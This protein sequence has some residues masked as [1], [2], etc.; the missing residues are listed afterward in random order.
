MKFATFFMFA[1][2]RRW[3]ECVYTRILYSTRNNT[4]MFARIR[5]TRQLYVSH[6]KQDALHVGTERSFSGT[7]CCV[8]DHSCSDNRTTRD[9]LNQIRRNRTLG[10]RQSESGNERTVIRFWRLNSLE[11]ESVRSITSSMHNLFFEMVLQYHGQLSIM[12]AHVWSE[13]FV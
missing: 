6:N 13:A 3:P 10:T 7:I 12:C 8:D 9:P 1:V 2:V 11:I 4:T 5:L